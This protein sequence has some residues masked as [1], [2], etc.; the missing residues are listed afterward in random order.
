MSDKFTSDPFGLFDTGFFEADSQN[1]E[2]FWKYE[3]KDGED[4]DMEG[5]EQV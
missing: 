3:N 5:E 4:T 2:L 1:E